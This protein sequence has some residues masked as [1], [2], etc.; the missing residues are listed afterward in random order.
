MDSQ[1]SFKQSFEKFWKNEAYHDIV[2]KCSDGLEVPANRYVLV[3]AAR[4]S[5]FEKMLLGHFGE[6]KSDAVECNYPRDIMMAVLEFMHTNDAQLLKPTIGATYDDNDAV[7]LTEMDLDWIQKQVK[8]AAASVYYDLPELGKRVDCVV[9]KVMLYNQTLAF[10]ANFA[11]SAIRSM[12][13]DIDSLQEAT[14]RLLSVQTIRDILIDENLQMD[15]STLFEVVR[16]WSAGHEEERKS[17]ARKL[18]EQHTSA[19]T[20]LIQRSSCHL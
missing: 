15:E 10:Q 2:L 11:L 12:T 4:S 13:V 3:V 7:Q 20:K 18:V 14:I 16:I 9:L 6:T 5:V 1:Q 8:L 19:W 17:S